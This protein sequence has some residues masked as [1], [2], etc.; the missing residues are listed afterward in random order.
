MTSYVQPKA[1]KAVPW[2]EIRTE[3]YRAR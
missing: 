2:P 3:F 1:L